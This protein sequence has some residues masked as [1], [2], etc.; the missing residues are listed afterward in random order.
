MNDLL[1]EWCPHQRR[2]SSCQVAR[3]LP[4][5]GPISDPL[6]KFGAY[7][8]TV[9][10]SQQSCHY[11]KTLLW[12]EGAKATFAFGKT[13]AFTKGLSLVVGAVTGVGEAKMADVAII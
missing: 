2:H 4:L 5:E 3:F 11:S 12:Y 6:L 13:I 8:Q 10:L 9:S 7:S 1:S